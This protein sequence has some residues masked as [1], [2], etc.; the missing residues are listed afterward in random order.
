MHR[1]HQKQRCKACACA[2]SAQSY[3]SCSLNQRLTLLRD[4]GN[5]PRSLRLWVVRPSVRTVYMMHST[6]SRSLL[7]P[8]PVQTLKPTEETASKSTAPSPAESRSLKNDLQAQEFGKADSKSDGDVRLGQS[9][10]FLGLGNT[11]SSG[12]GLRPKI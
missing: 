12:Y 4:R 2:I 7:S 1:H 10:V 3:L 9:R 6:D 11:D 8:H 5:P